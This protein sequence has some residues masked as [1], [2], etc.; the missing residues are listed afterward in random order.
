M[1]DIKENIRLI[2]IIVLIYKTNFTML[3]DKHN[4]GLRTIK[5]VLIMI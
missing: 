3:I 4:V 2:S 5:Y 1:V